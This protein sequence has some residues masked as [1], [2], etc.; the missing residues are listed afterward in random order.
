LTDSDGRPRNRDGAD[1]YLPPPPSSDEGPREDVKVPRV[2]PP[3]RA[4]E[5]YAREK[6]RRSRRGPPIDFWIGLVVLIVLAA[7]LAYLFR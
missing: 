2:N 5:A 1:I 7:A 4:L 6:P 3:S